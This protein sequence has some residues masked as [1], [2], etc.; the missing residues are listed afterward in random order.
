MTIIMTLLHVSARWQWG[1]SI[2]DLAC[3]TC[4]FVLVDSLKMVPR[5]R[6]MQEL[7]IIINSTFD[8]YFILFYW[9][10][11]F[12]IKPTRCTNFPTFS[13]AW[14]ST[15]FGQFLCIGICHTGLKTAFEQFHPSPAQKLSSNL[16]GTLLPMPSVQWI[17]SWWWAEELTETCRVSCRKKSGKIGASGWFYYKGIC[18]DARSYERKIY[19]V[20]L[21]ADISNAQYPLP[22]SPT[23]VPL[24]GH[25][26]PIHYNSTKFPHWVPYAL[27]PRAPHSPPISF[28]LIWS[29]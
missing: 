22:N 16:Y 25:T 4:S 17:N 20:H 14:N 7:I 24:L 23:C 1:P 5:C 21:L 12:I 27:P 26:K 6:N 8:L 10:P 19:W 18:Y 28:P 11:F 2:P 9:V 13:P 29:D 15:C 3:W